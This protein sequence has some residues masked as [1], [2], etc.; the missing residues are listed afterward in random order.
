MISGA[1][2][3]LLTFVRLLKWL[4]HHYYD[5]T[6]A[7]MMGLILGAL[8]RVWPW[9]ESVVVEGEIVNEY[10]VLP[11]AFTGDVALA[12]FLMVLGFG[13]VLLLDYLASRVAEERQVE[14]PEET[15]KAL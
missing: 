2:V 14:G 8:R 3:G 5:L 4:F 15:H 9:K 13:I 12:V 1:A 11:E 10:N 7:L 6:V